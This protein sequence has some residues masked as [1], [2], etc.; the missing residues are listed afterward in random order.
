MPEKIHSEALVYGSSHTFSCEFHCSLDFYTY[1]TIT[2]KIE[3]R[4]AQEFFIGNDSVCNTLHFT[5][6]L[7]SELINMLIVNKRSITRFLKETDRYSMN[8]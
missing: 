6:I 3:E 1:W 7:L 8:S 4:I 5:Y 2:E